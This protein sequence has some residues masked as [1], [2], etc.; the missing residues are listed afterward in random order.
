M[1]RRPCFFRRL[2]VLLLVFCCA[3]SCSDKQ[4][5]TEEETTDYTPP[6]ILNVKDIRV[7]VGETPDYLDGVYA[8]DLTDGAVPVEVD[9]SAVHTETMG[10]YTVVYFASDK[11]GNTARR[12]AQVAVTDFEDDDWDGAAADPDEVRALTEGVLAELFPDGTD[13]CPERTR[14]EAVYSWIT[15]NIRYR[16][17]RKEWDIMK[18]DAKAEAVLEALADRHGNCYTF[19]AVSEA[20]LTGAGLEN[21]KVRHVLDAEIHFW[22]LVSV[23]GKWLHF[24]TTPNLDGR[25]LNLF[26][27]TDEEIRAKHGEN[28]TFTVEGP[29]E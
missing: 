6:A 10:Y 15:E 23:D 11:A 17:G 1:N 3:V 16:G 14:A 4:A 5:E 22:N 12:T 19:Y 25:V 24:D 26:L 9:A 27:L 13:A 21:K 29:E 7:L 8:S 2:C 18:A 28:W 20:L